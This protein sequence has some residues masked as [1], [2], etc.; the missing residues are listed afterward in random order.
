MLHV[1]AVWKIQ[2]P[3]MFL[4]RQLGTVQPTSF[5]LLESFWLLFHPHKDHGKSFLC[6]HKVW[7]Q[8]AAV[9]Y[10]GNVSDGLHSVTLKTIWQP[11]VLSF[12]LFSVFFFSF[13]AV[14][15][16]FYIVYLIA[17]ICSFR[18][19]EENSVTYNMIA[20]LDPTSG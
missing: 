5:R 10:K 14:S 1:S 19:K 17:S 2:F 20:L 9:H 13:W 4:L 7:F 16:L 6:T 15:Q 11:R 18:R 8:L 12:L 3:K